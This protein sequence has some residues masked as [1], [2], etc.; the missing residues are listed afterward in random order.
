M[1]DKDLQDML[2]AMRTY[3]VELVVQ[4]FKA[5]DALTLRTRKEANL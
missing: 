2:S 1:T 4:G 5:E 3:Y